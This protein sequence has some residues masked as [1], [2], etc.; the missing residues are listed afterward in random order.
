VWGTAGLLL[1]L[2]V[3][4]ESGRAGWDVA[5]IDPDISSCCSALQAKLHR[6]VIALTLKPSS[7]RIARLGVVT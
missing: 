7:N 1:T 6:T 4:A 5:A 2:R 3:R